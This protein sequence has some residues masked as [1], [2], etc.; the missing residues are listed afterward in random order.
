MESLTKQAQP[1]FVCKCGHV[2]KFWI[3]EL[4]T[5][6]EHEAHEPGLV[7]RFVDMTNAKFRELADASAAV[8]KS[9]RFGR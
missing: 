3:D 2:F 1:Q 9:Q 4:K 5:V 8:A 7:N 6:R